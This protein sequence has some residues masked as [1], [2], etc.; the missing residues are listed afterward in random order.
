MEG[1]PTQWAPPVW[2]ADFGDTDVEFAKLQ[3]VAIDLRPVS[4]FSTA[5]VGFEE[6][7]M[8]LQ[9]TKSCRPFAEVYAILEDCRC[10]FGIF[11]FTPNGDEEYY[12]NTVAD[13]HAKLLECLD[14]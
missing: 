8:A 3:A 11:A 5:L 6:G 12:V 14:A 7:Y 10:R 2:H 1:D 13:V 9:V 4:V